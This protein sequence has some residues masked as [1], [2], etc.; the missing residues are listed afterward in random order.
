MLAPCLP[1]SEGDSALPCTWKD[2][3]W[4][5]KSLPSPRSL[6][7]KA[8]NNTVKKTQQSKH[9]PTK[10][11]IKCF[12]SVKSLALTCEHGVKDFCECIVCLALFLGF[13]SIEV[14]WATCDMVFRIHAPVEGWPLSFMRRHNMRNDNKLFPFERE[15]AGLGL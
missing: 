5:I 6:L 1:C 10:H 7:L 2:S 9:A 12:P 15:A 4:Y 8:V 14:S 3:R 11:S 13:I